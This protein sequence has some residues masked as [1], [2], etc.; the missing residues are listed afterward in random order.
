LI[1]TKAS[2]GGASEQATGGGEGLTQY[3]RNQEEE[4]KRRRR[5]G[6]KGGSGRQ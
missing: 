4:E 6:E 2:L 1:H 3:I 5:R